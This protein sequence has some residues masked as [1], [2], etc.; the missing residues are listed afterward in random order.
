MSR[1]GFVGLV[2]LTAPAAVLAACTASPSPAPTTSSP[3]GGGGTTGA[4]SA[5]GPRPE[6]VRSFGPNGT[7]WPAHTPWLG[8]ENVAVT[9]VDCDWEAIS[10]AIAAVTPEQAAAGVHIKIR[11]GTLPGGGSS[12]GSAGVLADI[13]SADWAQNVLVSPL[14]GRGSVTIDDEARLV[15]V[16]GVTFARLDGVVILMTNCT[17]S[18]WA[19]SKMTYGFR[20]AAS[21]GETTRE[22]GAYEIV[23]ADAKADIVDPFGYASGEGSLITDCVWEGCYGAPVF[24]PSGAD[25]HVDSLQMY[26]TGSYRGLTLRDTAVFGSLNCALQL[27]G[28]ADDD[29]YKGSSPFATLDHTLLTSQATAIQVRYP[30]PDGADTPKMAQAINGIGEPQHLYANDSLIF[31][32][33]HRS[34]W[35]VVSNCKVSSE[36]ALENNAIQDGKWTYDAD[37]A[38]WGAEEFDELA[39]IP[40]DEYLASVWT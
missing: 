21:Y 14:E 37:M 33:M 12:S 15:G 20:M 30:T 10:E 6:V 7:H 8:D 28:V 35:A 23:M 24:R 1:R 3:T 25:D 26:G 27:G 19:H 40:T 36:G 2:L 29:P 18:A 39:P 32:S 31:G 38:D 22:C 16:H 4:P 13:G 17:R 34:S 11:P 9:E 5:P